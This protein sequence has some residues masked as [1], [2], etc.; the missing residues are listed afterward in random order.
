MRSHQFFIAI[1]VLIGF[2]SL[3]SASGHG[4]VFGFATPVNS[5]GEWSFDLGVY[6]RAASLGSQTSVQSMVSYGLTPQL[7]WSAVL[8]GLVQRGSLP[9][10]PMA[11]GD[12][13]SSVAWRFIHH[14]NGIGR[15][16][17]STAS[18]GLVLPGPQQSFGALRGAL[19]NTHYA[20]GINS[21]V[22]TGLASRSHYLWAGGGFTRFAE[23]GGDRRSRVTS[24]SLVY[25]YRPESWRADRHQWDWRL[26]AEMTGEHSGLLQRA[27]A[28]IPGSDAN[29]AFLGPTFL[30][31]YKFFA[32]SGGVQLPVYSDLG[33]LYPHERVRVALNLSYF[34]F[35]HS[36]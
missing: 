14:P 6:G 5:Q 30:G 26:F 20:P 27:G 11:S 25:G 4:P 10:S 18:V 9:M 24:A 32:V 16:L 19:R 21:W 29:Q 7:Q 2:S 8:P 1:F 15:R 36:H 12:F 28:V 17:E 13:A 22:A 34:L 35:S 33:K 23:R 3:A 31:I